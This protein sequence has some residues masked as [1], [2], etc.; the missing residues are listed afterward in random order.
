MSALPYWVGGVPLHKDYQS[1]QMQL[2]SRLMCFFHT[3][4]AYVSTNAWSD[5]SWSPLL[6]ILD[7]NRVPQEADPFPPDF[8]FQPSG[9]LTESRHLNECHLA[10]LAPPNAAKSRSPPHQHNNWGHQSCCR[11]ARPIIAFSSY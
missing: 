11:K 10:P 6:S 8:Y 4:C 7:S 1:N 5:S 9:L 2:D 3:I